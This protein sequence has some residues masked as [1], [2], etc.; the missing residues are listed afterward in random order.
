MS[1][2]FGYDLKDGDKILEAPDKLAS[3]LR[4][5]TVPVRGALVNLL[6]FCA[7]VNSSL[8]ACNVLWPFSVRHIPSWVPYLSYEPLARIG[9]EMAERMKNEPIDFVKTALV[10]GHHARTFTFI[11]IAYHSIMALRCIHWRASI[12]RS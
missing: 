11:Q 2:T 10:C 8:P 3:I 12:C 4:P 9:R 1:L 5:V 6:P 7:G